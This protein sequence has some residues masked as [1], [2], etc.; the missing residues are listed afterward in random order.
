VAAASG[1]ALGAG[2]DVVAEQLDVVAEQRD[3]EEQD[4]MPMPFM[5]LYINPRRA[6]SVVLPFLFC[7]I[8]VI[9]RT[10]F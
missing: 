3:V 10:S 8:L 4:V 9:F 2:L 7:F 6:R 5:P 1:V